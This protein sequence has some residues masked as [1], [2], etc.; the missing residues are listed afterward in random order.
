MENIN[1][2]PQSHGE[3]TSTMFRGH[4]IYKKSNRTMSNTA[5]TQRNIMCRPHASTTKVR[6]VTGIQRK[7]DIYDQP[8]AMAGIS[9]KQRFSESPPQPARHKPPSTRPLPKTPPS[10]RNTIHC[11]HHITASSPAKCRRSNRTRPTTTPEHRETY[12]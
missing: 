7:S 6:V 5:S 12:E 11:P 4:P 8:Q 9:Q 1:K 10:Y 3:T 2:T